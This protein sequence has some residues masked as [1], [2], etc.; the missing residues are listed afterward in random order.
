MKKISKLILFIFIINIIFISTMSYA[1]VYSDVSLYELETYLSS[2]EAGDTIKISSGIYND[3]KININVS[4]TKENPILIKPYSV[5]GVILTGDCHISISGKYVTLSG[6]YFKDAN[7]L[8]DTDL[9]SITNGEGIRITDCFFERASGNG[10]GGKIISIQNNSSYNRIDHC[11]FYDSRSIGIGIYQV[12]DPLGLM[13]NVANNK[14]DHNYFKKV[15]A[16]GELYP[17]KSNGLECLQIGTGGIFPLYTEVSY[18]LF[19]DC[20]GDGAEVVSNKSS[21]NTYKFNTFLN[22]PSSTFC[23]RSGDNNTVYGNYFIN[24][25]DGVRAYGEGNIIANNYFYEIRRN[26][27]VLSSCNEQSYTT[28]KNF[29]VAN[30]TI[31]NPY[32]AGISIGVKMD[33]ASDCVPENIRVVNNHIISEKGKTIIFEA[34]KNVTFSNNIQ[35]LNGYA[36]SDVEPYYIEKYSVKREIRIPFANMVFRTINTDGN[37]YF[38]GEIY[39]PKSVNDVKEKGETLNEIEEIDEVVKDKTLDIGV[40]G[41]SDALGK[42]GIITTDV[43]GPQDK[44]WLEF[45]EETPSLYNKHEYNEIPYSYSPFKNEIFIE[46]DKE[47]NLFE[48]SGYATYQTGERFNVSRNELIFSLDEDVNVATL[49]KN[50][51]YPKETGTFDIDISYRG[52]QKTVKVNVIEKNSFQKYSSNE[53]FEKFDTETGTKTVDLDL[54]NLSAGTIA[55]D[56]T[57]VLSGNYTISTVAK[58]DGAKIILGYNNNTD[59]GALDGYNLNNSYYYIKVGK[60]LSSIYKYNGITDIKV[61][62]INYSL[63][64][65]EFHNIKVNVLENTLTVFIDDKFSGVYKADESISGRVGVGSDT[66]NVVFESYETMPYLAEEKNLNETL[67]EISVNEENK[68]S[69]SFDLGIEN[70]IYKLKRNGILI[71]DFYSPDLVSDNNAYLNESYKYELSGYDSSGNEVLSGTKE[72]EFSK[73]PDN[74]FY[75]SDLYV[76]SGNGGTYIKGLYKVDNKGIEISKPAFSQRTYAYT[77]IPE[78]LMGCQY[79]LCDYNHRTLSSAK[80]A[81]EWLKFNLH[82]SPC[83]VYVVIYAENPPDWL[84]QNDWQLTDMTVMAETGTDRVETAKV[85]KKSFTLSEGGYET[86]T[87]GGFGD[88]IPYGIIVKNN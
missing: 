8:S 48:L 71:G 43:C 53:D 37:S 33:D 5:G 41:I 50:I 88:G 35:R 81:S 64:D 46:K 56:N 52:K 63:Q 7:S 19:E 44:W 9:I 61:G 24:M 74:I 77:S 13:S 11:T 14:I 31:V 85:Y 1:Y 18:N 72:Y 20:R 76:K 6:F 12:D 30:N 34:G 47:F 68:L 3:V 28:P 87:L 2:A 62:D 65:E 78:E 51:L 55:I 60:D 40:I 32:Y 4:G 36:K 21:Y 66:S 86:V 67:L 16:V 54:L 73:I 29:L 26:S 80:S 27:I 45:I 15:R 22:N 49:N 83:D 38:N 17:G 39:V 84:S 82:N 58:G 70:L 42:R 25:K 57:A 59:L 79:I 69:I 75:I 23:L 10:A